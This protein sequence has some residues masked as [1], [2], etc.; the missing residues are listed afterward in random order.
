MPKELSA[1]EKN[2]VMQAM[3]DNMDAQ[4]EPK[5][6]IFWYD[7]NRNELFG[8]TKIEASELSY[9]SNGLKTVKTLHKNYWAKQEAKDRAKGQKSRFT[10]DY[11]QVPRG[12]IFQRKSGVFEIMVGDWIHGRESAI[13]LILI[14][15][16]LQQAQTE[17]VEDEHWDIGHGWSE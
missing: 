14:E 11:T 1:K 15:F 8:I 12:R 16:D 17:V 2:E 4:D 10:G 5:V 13:D 9:N 6:G 3:I 7:Q